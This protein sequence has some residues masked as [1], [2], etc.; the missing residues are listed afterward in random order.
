MN[1]LI[2]VIVP[3]YNAAKYLTKCIDSIINQT[4]QN[5]EIILVDDG[6]TDG[7]GEI[8]DRYARRDA[9]VKVI[10][11]RNGGVSSARNCGLDA[12][13]GSFVTFVDSDD[14]LELS[15]AKMISDDM[16]ED[17]DIALYS[18][19]QQKKNGE[20]IGGHIYSEDIF[21]INSMVGQQLYQINVATPVAIAF[22]CSIIN[23]NNLR[24]QQNYPMG[25]DS[26]FSQQ[27]LLLISKGVRLS[28][29]VVYHYVRWNPDSLS[30]KYV[31]NIEDIYTSISEVQEQLEEKYG[32]TYVY[33]PKEKLVATMAIQ[34]LY[35]NQCPLNRKQRL[36]RIRHYMDDEAT[37]KAFLMDRCRDRY[38]WIRKQL[39]VMRSPGL[40]DLV[41]TLG[42]I[43][44][45]NSRK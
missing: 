34:N 3:V 8:C 24:F 2:S 20:V 45:D 9:R 22:R 26:L 43:K 29:Q 30:N 41:Y 5:V 4:Y 19:I 39:M 37:Q 7:S 16:N 10:H 36:A 27:Y 11:K 42:K 1:E 6:S 33:V 14:Y 38:D 21:I 12:A 15:F 40:L 35:A 44:R 18:M 31:E 13:T 32:A 25:E 23:D 28:S 17:T